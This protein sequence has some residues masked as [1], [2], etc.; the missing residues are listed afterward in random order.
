MASHKAWFHGSLGREVEFCFRFVMVRLKIIL[1]WCLRLT[2]HFNLGLP[3]L[4][5]GMMAWAGV[6][7]GRSIEAATSPLKGPAQ[8]AGRQGGAIGKGMLTKG[9]GARR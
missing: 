1:G 2:D 6:K 4:W 8:D 7:A 9:A 5:S 3:L